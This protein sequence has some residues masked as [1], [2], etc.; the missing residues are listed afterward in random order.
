MQTLK[1]F[2]Y[3]VRGLTTT[4][5]EEFNFRI[6]VLVGLVVFFCMFYF[7]FSYIESALCVVAVALVLV[8]EVINTIVEDFCDKVEP[9]Q[10]KIIE[11][12]KDMSASF[13]L[14]STLASVTIGIFVLLNHFN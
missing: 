2:K 7:D 11:K 12:I 1:S 6:E 9:N 5:R 4:W 3:A 8:S 10:D 13:V 14:L